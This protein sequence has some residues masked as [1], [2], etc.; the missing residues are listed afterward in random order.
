[1]CWLKHAS[2]FCAQKTT[3]LIDC[4]V[5]FKRDYKDKWI[6]IDECWELSEKYLKAYPNSYDKCCLYITGY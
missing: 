4:N 1:M 3:R 6:V 2:S 5:Q